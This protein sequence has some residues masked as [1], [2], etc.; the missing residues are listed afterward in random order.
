MTNTNIPAELITATGVY[1]TAPM[2]LEGITIDGVRDMPK[3]W[4]YR[5]FIRETESDAIS[6]WAYLPTEENHETCLDC[7][8]RKTHDHHTA[9][10]IQMEDLVEAIAAYRQSQIESYLDC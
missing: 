6:A 4:A 9:E 7:A 5:V 1:G 2:T 3:G 10:I 8:I